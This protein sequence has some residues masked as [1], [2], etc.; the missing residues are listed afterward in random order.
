MSD[1]LQRAKNRIRKELEATVKAVVTE[2]AAGKISREVNQAVCNAIEAIFIHG[3]KDA[4]FLKGSRYSK[5]PEPNFW[6]FVSKFT[7]RSIQSQISSQNQIKNEIGKG[8][9]WIRIVLNDG[10]LEHYVSMITKDT[11]QLQQFYNDSAFLRDG[12]KVETLIGYLKALAKV[13]L[14]APT[15]STFL[16]TWTPTPLVLAGLV[17]EKSVKVSNLMSPKKDVEAGNPVLNLLSPK[18]LS[19]KGSRSSL[20]SKEDDERSSVYSHPSIVDNELDTPTTSEVSTEVIV[21]RSKGR[22]RYMSH[23]SSEGQSLYSLSNSSSMQ[24]LTDEQEEKETVMPA[25]YVQSKIDSKDGDSLQLGAVDKQH[26]VKQLE[27]TTS[28]KFVPTLKEDDD[29]ATIGDGM[30][31]QQSQEHPS[32]SFDIAAS[33]MKEFINDLEPEVQLKK[34]QELIET[35]F[36]DDPSPYDDSVDE[37]SL[38]LEANEETSPN[39]V[40]VPVNCGNSLVGKGWQISESSMSSAA[41]SLNGSEHLIPFGEA[42]REVMHHQESIESKSDLD[43]RSSEMF[44]KE[45]PVIIEAGELPDLAE[46]NELSREKELYH[47]LI[48]IPIEKGLDSQGFRCPNCRRSIGASF[49]TYRLCNFDGLHY[50][51]H[52]FK[53]FVECP[54]PARIMFNWD[55]RPRAITRTA[56]ETLQGVYEK[57]LFQVNEINRLLYTQ[58][59][60]LDKIRRLREKLSLVSMYLLSCKQSVAE[61]LKRRLW[62]NDYL[63]TDI[64]LYSIKDLENIPTGV[65]ERRLNTVI[66]FAV[67]HVAS[68]VLCI[69]KGFIC[70]IC[71]SRKVIY[72]FQTETTFRCKKC[73]SVYHKT[74]MEGKECPR[75]LRQKKNEQRLRQMESF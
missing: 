55:H 24:K 30:A 58:A 60:D 17:Q 54:I 19:L 28:G 3:L 47:T 6:P 13:S 25:V 62:P 14:N 50:C 39:E 41:S 5:Y 1:V 61:D 42:M 57:P 73:F 34:S 43:E 11:Q 31:V 33:S 52:C 29:R 36:G 45:E 48:T 72:S 9:T 23:S 40:Y 26:D 44:E 16:N 68:C 53:R 66:N 75:C 51:E 70:E 10:A 8:R 49:G 15:N 64:H 27:A 56:F 67:E 63:H 4:F 12:D 71:N 21:Q 20:Q 38:K 74:C 18:T 46:T 65:L 2:D 32:L 59:E 22:R 35:N 37:K 7:H 69:Q